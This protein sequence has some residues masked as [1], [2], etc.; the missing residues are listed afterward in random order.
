MFVTR[1][2]K[3][4]EHFYYWPVSLKSCESSE[5]ASDAPCMDSSASRHKLLCEQNKASDS[6]LACSSVCVLDSV[7]FSQIVYRYHHL[8]SVME[9]G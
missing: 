5:M 6:Q 3:Q 7:S 9:D 2:H 1:F 8:V 4:L